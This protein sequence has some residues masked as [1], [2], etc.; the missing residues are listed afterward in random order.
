MSF[1]QNDDGLEDIGNKQSD[2]QCFIPVI[3]N[4]TFNMLQILKFKNDDG[5]WYD[6]ETNDD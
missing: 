1:S 6:M 4:N 2:G 5:Y 3:A